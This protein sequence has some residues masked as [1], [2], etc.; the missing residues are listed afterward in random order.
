MYRR[1]IDLR[2]LACLFSL[3]F[4]QVTFDENSMDFLGMT[5]NL[6]S[7][8]YKLSNSSIVHTFNATGERLYLIDMIRS[9]EIL[10]PKLFQDFL[11]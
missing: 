5:V 2:V 8:D 4:L 10:A 6:I 1:V 3:C 11:N 7:V 9:A